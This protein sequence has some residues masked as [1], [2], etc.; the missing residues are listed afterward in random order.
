[1]NDTQQR[2]LREI[3]DRIPAA[4]LHEVRLFPAIRQGGIESG[5][6]IVA[7]QPLSAGPA[8]DEAA[9]TKATDAETPLTLVRE[10]F[11]AEQEGPLPNEQSP[12]YEILSA[13]YKLVLKGAERG[14]WECEVR[15]EADAPLDT[16]DRV[17]RGVALR[18]G[19]EGEP[20]QIDVAALRT[21]IGDAAAAARMP[22]PADDDG[23][24]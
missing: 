3:G 23:A 24:G 20:Q 15:H 5:V 1:M 14:K 12:R 16:I 13:R 19:E 4:R 9:D 2:F 8:P 10:P 22:Q 18:S 21:L 6:A 17:V 11:E 7:A